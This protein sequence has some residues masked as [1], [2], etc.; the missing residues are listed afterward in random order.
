LHTLD[1]ADG[2][3]TL[4]RAVA[5]DVRHDCNDG[6]SLFGLEVRSHTVQMGEITLSTKTKTDTMVGG[7]GTLAFLFH[8]NFFS[9]MAQLP[10]NRYG[11]SFGNNG[12]GGGIF[13]FL[14]LFSV[15]SRSIRGDAS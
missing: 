12:A 4:E 10:S 15:F 7:G 3:R 1:N 11:I 13:S 14:H 9:A 6:T 5:I 8:I 2:S